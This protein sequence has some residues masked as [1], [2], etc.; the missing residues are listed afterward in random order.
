MSPPEGAQR[1]AP[2]PVPAVAVI[3]PNWNG[4]HLLPTCLESLRRQTDRF[5]FE[6]VVIDNAS[7][8]ASRALLRTDFPE[9]RVIT[10]PKNVFFAGA[11]NAGIR[12]TTTPYLA[13]LNNDTEVEPGWLAA[14]VAALEGCPEAGLAA[15]KMLLFDRRD[16]INSA[17]DLYRTD[18]TPGN[19][20][21]WEI[22]QGQ[23]DDARQVFG[24]CGGAALYRRGMLDEI[25]LFDEDFVGYCED[26]DLNFRAQLAGYRCIFVPEARIYHRL[27]A[28]GGGPIASY[29]CGRN[30]VNVIVKDLPGPLL[31]RFWPRILAAQ[32]R[33][34]WASLRHIREPAARA[35]L[36]GQA[37]A[38]LA[39]PAMLR[40]RRSIQ[41]TRRVDLAY[42]ESILTPD[43][44]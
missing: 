33:L 10:L 43:R 11:V 41:A 8:D 16:V 36:R 15:S 22:D 5:A 39:L 21:V 7:T 32:V 17:G 28:T 13:L 19:R 42:L 37:A 1:A 35:R 27:S 6:T 38:G 12:A 24:A 14:L 26:V 3:I 34:S 20:G 23:Y 9:V 40:K 44:T 18:G 29:F 4:A 2:V 31:R 25:G 30:F